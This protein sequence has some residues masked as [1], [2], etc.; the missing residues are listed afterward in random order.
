[1]KWFCG[2]Q[3]ISASSR[4]VFEH[5]KGVY[6]LTVRKLTRQDAGEWKCVAVNSFGRATC[7]CDLKVVGE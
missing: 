6:R 7:S 1:M 4:H 3:Q 2:D 5:D